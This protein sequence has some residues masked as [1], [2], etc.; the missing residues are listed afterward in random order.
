MIHQQHSGLSEPGGPGGHCPSIFLTDKLTLSQ[1]GV[2]YP[3]HI[4][5]YL[6]PPTFLDLPTV[7]TLLDCWNRLGTTK[8]GM[9]LLPVSARIAS[10]NK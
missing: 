2:D 9:S 3:H 5:Y 1:L 6:P 4:D 10:F 8:L 7:L